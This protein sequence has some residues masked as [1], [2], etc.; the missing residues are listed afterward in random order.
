MRVRQ[1][2]VGYTTGEPRDS[3][4]GF[5]DGATEFIEARGST[6]VD[7]LDWTLDGTVAQ[8]RPT[9]PAL[10]APSESP[11]SRTPLS[12]STATLVTPSCSS[13]PSDSP[14]KRST[15]WPTDERAEPSPRESAHYRRIHTAAL[16]TGTS[17]HPLDPPHLLFFGISVREHLG[18]G[19]SPARATA[20]RPENGSVRATC[21]ERSDQAQRHRVV[22]ALG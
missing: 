20:A 16:A 18:A 9:T 19:P 10:T 22:N 11:T 17:K 21:D 3:V 5:T 6:E 12:W 14:P 2:R 1:G 7:L 13:A 8:R 4:E 15:S